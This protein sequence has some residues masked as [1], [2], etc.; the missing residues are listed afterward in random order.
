M[1]EKCSFSVVPLKTPR[2]A[3]TQKFYNFNYTNQDYGSLKNRLIGLL[4]NNF[5]KDFNDIS[6]SSLAVMLIECW[7]A[8]A[9]MLSFKI[10]QLANEFFIDTASE[11]ENIFRLT[12]L[13][14]MRPLP[15]LPSR[16]MFMA[17]MNN[18]Y[19]KDVV[20]KCPVVVSLK[21]VGLNVFYELYPA[22]AD[23][24][25]VFGSDIIIPAGKLF[26]ESIVG[27]EGMTRTATFT[28][29]GSGGQ[30][31]TLPQENVYYKSIRLSVDNVIWQEVDSFSRGA[32]QEYMIDYEAFYKPSIIFGDNIVGQV[33][34]SG[35]KINVSYRV[36]GGYT[37]EIISGAFDTKVFSELP[38][39]N[40][41]IVINVKNYTKSEYGYTGDDV[42]T[43][44]SKLPKYIM[45]QSRAVTG[46]DYKFLVDSFATAHDG[47]VAKSNIALRNHGC[48]GNVI[49]II[50]LAKNGNYN[51][52]KASP[53]LKK[54][55]TEYMNRKKMFT[56]HICIKDGD[57]IPVDIHIDVN[58]SKAQNNL[59]PD[60]RSK[61]TDALDIFFS[62]D[63][64]EFGRSLREKDIIKV[65][66]AI[67]EIRNLD[68][69][70]T[71][72]KTI[73]NSMESEPVVVADYNELI[74]PDN[75]NVN[76][77]YEDGV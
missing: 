3:A 72:N 45:S 65:L 20:L 70:F 9:D 13:V 60:I 40:S 47:A 28:S 71:T 27:I 75:I 35:A 33:P 42:A 12:K 57:V 25:P 10:D 1:A 19:S 18:I 11:V 26:T 53:N 4:K 69:K 21:E 54:S 5:D 49:D 77:V 55:L 15:P 30:I 43:I 36:P 61:I 34:R 48:A 41:H 73:E 63:E 59:E 51:I 44:K 62:I 7:A 16:A 56:D 46:K 50:I 6:E 68:V 58:V 23:N 17:K 66:A 32:K 24:N 74:R 37:A 39:I 31:F 14:G 2:I 52:S 76:F 22:G 29:N 64:W 38:G 8:I 67:K